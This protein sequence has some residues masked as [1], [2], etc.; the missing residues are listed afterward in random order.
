MKFVI[1]TFLTIG[2]LTGGWLGSLLD[3]GFGAWS[4]LLG[5][6]IGP[7]LGIYIGYKA[8]KAWLE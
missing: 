7:L 6:F 8:G 5:A 4:F 1:F 2:G 3:G